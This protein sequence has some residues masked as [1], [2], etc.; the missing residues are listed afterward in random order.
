MKSVCVIQYGLGLSS[1]TTIYTLFDQYKHFSP[2]Y[3]FTRVGVGR[4]QNVRSTL[5]T[6]ALWRHTFGLT[7]VENY[8]FSQLRHFWMFLLVSFRSHWMLLNGR[9]ISVTIQWLFI[10]RGFKVIL[11]WI[12]TPEK[13]N[14]NGENH[15]H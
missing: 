1:K 11:L 13:N 5:R 12:R 15:T 10:S 8:P 7:Q 6:Y 4:L 9:H 3:R 14:I 2:K